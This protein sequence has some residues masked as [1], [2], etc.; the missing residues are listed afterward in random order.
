MNSNMT[1]HVDLE[2]TDLADLLAFYRHG[3]TADIIQAREGNGWGAVW[4]F[5]PCDVHAA[6]RAAWMVQ[7][8]QKDTRAAVRHA[9]RAILHDRSRKA[10]ADVVV[11]TQLLVKRTQ[12]VAR[13]DDGILIRVDA[14][15]E[16]DALAALEA[17]LGPMP[18]S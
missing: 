5:T 8:L 13:I 17:A 14:Y 3:N 10:N 11:V 9:R 7:R 18:R 4:T 1:R 6:E 12:A 16:D 15:L 2:Q